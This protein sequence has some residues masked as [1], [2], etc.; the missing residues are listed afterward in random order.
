[1]GQRKYIFE[2][3]VQFTYLTV[4]KYVS[5]DRGYYECLCRCGAVTKFRGC[6]LARGAIKSC[7]C[8]ASD[9]A[10]YMGNSPTY[11][12]WRGLRDRCKKKGHHNYK[13]YGGRGITY[14]PRWNNFR[15]FLKDMGERPE[16]MTLDRIDVNGNYCKDNCK[17]STPK[18]QGNNTRFNV[19][20]EYNGERLTVMQWA[21]KLGINW[22]T[23]DGRLRRGWSVERALTEVVS[24]SNTV[25]KLAR[26][27][28]AGG[29]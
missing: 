29:V 23:I 20:L 4:V 5:G 3:G 16:G 25:H 11:R 24:L 15:E 12:S 18:E 13:L 19:F 8:W 22:A 26:T 7:G 6:D 28:P 14:D 1:M 27:P 2:P 17:W 10:H 9:N 21:D